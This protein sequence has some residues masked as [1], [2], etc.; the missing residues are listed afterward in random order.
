[1]T[2]FDLSYAYPFMSLN[3]VIVAFLS[4]WLFGEPFSAQKGVGLGLVVLG[5]VI[6]GR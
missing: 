5:I 2:K 6:G 3:F 4:V 1:M